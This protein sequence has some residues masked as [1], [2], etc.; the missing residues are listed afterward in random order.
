MSSTGATAIQRSLSARS[1][2]LLFAAIAHIAPVRNG[3][4]NRS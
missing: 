4:V 1:E 3:L 2:I